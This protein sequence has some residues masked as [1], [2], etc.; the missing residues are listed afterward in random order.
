MEEIRFWVER[1]A[2]EYYIQDDNFTISRKR[3]IE[4][5]RLLIES[6]LKIKYKISSRVDYLDDKLMYYLE[7]SGCYRIHFG[8]ESG[9]PKMLD[10]LQKGIT[11]KQIKDTFRLAKKHGID[12]FAYIMIGIPLE[13]QEDIDMTLGLIRDIKPEHLHCSICT[14]MP[15]T[16]L[17][18]KLMEEEI[19]KHDYWLAFAKN[20]DPAFKT[21]FSS[22]FFNNKKLRSMQDSIQRQFY[23]NPKTILREIGRTRGPKQF[24]TKAKL[25]LKMILPKLYN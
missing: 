7:R 1:G 8:I 14:P 18:R 2:K 3:T 17:Y 20:P 5:C 13:R 21:P 4:F 23:L 25:A 24:L 11:V 10:Y 6:D 22:P 16:Y 12:R 9:S 15:K 19:I